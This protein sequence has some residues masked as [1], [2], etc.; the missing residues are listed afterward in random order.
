MIFNNAFTV[1]YFVMFLNIKFTRPIS[2]NQI[3]GYV[4]VLHGSISSSSSSFSEF[5]LFY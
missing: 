3:S 2:E 5:F 1:I 4:N